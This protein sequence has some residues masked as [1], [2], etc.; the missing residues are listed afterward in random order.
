MLASIVLSA[1]RWRELT[2]AEEAAAVAE[3]RELAARRADL[4]AEVAGVPRAPVKGS[5]VSRSSGRVPHR[6]G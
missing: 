6:R 1:T 4:L 3:L 5:P 2:D